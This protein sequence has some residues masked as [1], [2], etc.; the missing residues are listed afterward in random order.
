M[1]RLLLLLLALHATLA[2]AQKQAYL[3]RSIK[4][5][6]EIADRDNQFS[7]L[8]RY[9]NLLLLLSESRLQEHAEAKVYALDFASLDAQLTQQTTELPYKKYLLRNLDKL[10]ARIDSTGQHYEGLEGMTVLGN[11]A[12]FSVETATSS[13]YCYVLRG[14]ID[15]ARNTITLDTHYLVPLAK[16]TLSNGTH[17]YNAGFE[18]LA[19]YGQNL[20]LLYEHNYFTHDNY[21]FTL[22]TPD[23][24]PDIPQY[25]SVKR[26]PFRVTDM[27]P[28]GKNRFIGINY[29]FSGA[30]DSVYRPAPTDPNTKFVRAGA[31]YQNY[32]RLIS[33]R[34]K[35][36]RISWKPLFELPKQ[37]ML[38][39]WEGLAAY[40]GGYFLIND[41]YGPSNQ[42]TLLYLQKR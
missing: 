38:Y 39:N 8:C 11:I 33:L 5:P 42:S 26:L 21:A 37:Y 16:P 2:S 25:V 31:G 28:T 19:S 3:P 14:P 4:L 27:V 6:A 36:G 1:K 9:G 30:E 17:I 34:Y 32:C 22:P 40:R 23:D 13:P 10:R 7:G 20:L 29:F 12:Y 41:K 15:D 24:A 35:H 18:A